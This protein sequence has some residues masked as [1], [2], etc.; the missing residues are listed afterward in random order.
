MQRPT[1]CKEVA[2]VEGNES[3]EEHYQRLM[4][5][6]G[7]GK[8]SDDVDVPRE[9]GQIKLSIKDWERRVS[10]A[11]YFEPDYLFKE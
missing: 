2:A 10:K 1:S 11:H 5:G 7:Q 6:K 9:I 4:Q 8:F 3:F